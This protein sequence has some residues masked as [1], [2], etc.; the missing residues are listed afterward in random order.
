MELCRFISFQ[1]LNFTGHGWVCV[2]ARSRIDIAQKTAVVRVSICSTHRI[3]SS[4]GIFERI[5][6][7]SAASVN[8]IVASRAREAHA[9]QRFT[10]LLRNFLLRRLRVF[11][12]KHIERLNQRSVQSIQP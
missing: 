4:I 2:S 11:E 9:M 8:R 12:E 1:Q 7:R 5:T 6:K 3:E 10:R